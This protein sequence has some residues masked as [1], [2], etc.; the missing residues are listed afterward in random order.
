MSARDAYGATSDTS[1]LTYT[2]GA[3]R[4]SNSDRVS[5]RDAVDI[6]GAILFVMAGPIA[7]VLATAVYI[8]RG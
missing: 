2:L 1:R 6:T 3:Q 5:L 4:D 8:L 7:T